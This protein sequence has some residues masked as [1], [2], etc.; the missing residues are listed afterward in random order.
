MLNRT[1]AFEI[2]E[3]DVSGR[4]GWS[5]IVVGGAEEVVAPEELTVSVSSASSRG[6]VRTETASCESAEEVSGRRVDPDA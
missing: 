5:V 2:D 6:L 4:T 1:V 3:F